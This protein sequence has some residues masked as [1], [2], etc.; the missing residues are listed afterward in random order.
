[1]TLRLAGDPRECLRRL[2]QL[3]G[4]EDE[5]SHGQAN[6]LFERGNALVELHDVEH[7]RQAYTAACDIF[8]SFQDSCGVANCERALGSAAAQ[9]GRLHEAQRHLNT[10]IARYEELRLPPPLA[11]ALVVRAQV[12]LDLGEGPA[13]A[14]DAQKAQR[15][16]TGRSEISSA[17]PPA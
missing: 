8:A 12:R 16:S 13:A 10:A 9:L 17:S 11:N 14:E 15:S 4:G 3:L 2:D 7:A 6:I 5:R 1:M